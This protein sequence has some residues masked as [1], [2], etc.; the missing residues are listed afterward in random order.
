MNHAAGS[1]GFQM[2]TQ[3][4]HACMLH[5]RLH[6]WG[7]PQSSTL[8]D[9]RLVQGRLVHARGCLHACSTCKALLARPRLLSAC[10]RRHTAV[11]IRLEHSG[12]VAALLADI[13]RL[14]ARRTRRTV[15]Y[16]LGRGLKF[17]YPSGGLQ[18]GHTAHH[19]VACDERNPS[20][21]CR[22]AGT[23]GKRPKT[24]LG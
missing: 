17:S 6:V 1:C 13:D 20:R 23:A 24:T 16:R 3:G 19:C 18:I 5:H 14:V 12:C 2:H 15:T 11:A 7:M 8:G 10:P 9:L 4:M 22:A 21:L